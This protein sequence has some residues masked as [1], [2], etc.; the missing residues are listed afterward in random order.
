MKGKVE[1]RIGEVEEWS[2]GG[3]EGE[4]WRRTGRDGKGTGG[5]EMGKGTVRKRQRQINRQMKRQRRGG[6]GRGEREK[7]VGRVGM[8]GI[9]CQS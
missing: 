9:Y 1:G 8:I 6:G 4:G 5:K 7:T 3:R 2:E